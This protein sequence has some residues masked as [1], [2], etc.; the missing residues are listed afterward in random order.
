MHPKGWEG[1][2][3]CKYVCGWLYD[4]YIVLC[5]MT[6]YQQRGHFHDYSNNH[7]FIY[8]NILCTFVVVEIALQGDSYFNFIDHKSNINFDILFIISDTFCYNKYLSSMSIIYTE[9]SRKLCFFSKSKAKH[10]P[11]SG[12][13]KGC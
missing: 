6:R 1:R 8:T 4:I 10:P 3:W 9:G 12:C 5:C 2:W 7:K 11:P 13:C